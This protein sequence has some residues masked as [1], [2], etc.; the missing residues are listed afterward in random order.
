MQQLQLVLHWFAGDGLNR[1]SQLGVR[2]DRQR[3]VAWGEGWDHDI[4]HVDL[5]LLLEEVDLML[6]LNQLLLLLG[7]LLLLLPGQLHLL[8]LFLEK[9]GSHVLLL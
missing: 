8:L 7:D 2:G 3:L 1:Q 4:R 6:L 5:D 9:H